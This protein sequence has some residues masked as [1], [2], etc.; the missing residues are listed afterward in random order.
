MSAQKPWQVSASLM[1]K[2]PDRNVDGNRNVGC[3]ID[4]IDDGRDAQRS[5]VRDAGQNGALEQ[6]QQPGGYRQSYK[7]CVKR[8]AS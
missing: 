8:E 3:E 7:A 6:R 4:A 5:D 1:A 2:H